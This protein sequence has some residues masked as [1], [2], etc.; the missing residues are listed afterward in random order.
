[1]RNDHQE[2]INFEPVE[3]MIIEPEVS[4]LVENVHTDVRLDF[5]KVQTVSE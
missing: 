5:I 3:I 1:M 4:E 2:E